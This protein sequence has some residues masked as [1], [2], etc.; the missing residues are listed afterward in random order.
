MVTPAAQA[1]ELNLVAADAQPTEL[2]SGAGGHVLGNELAERLRTLENEEAAFYA[3]K[4]LDRC[5]AVE[6]DA[7]LAIVDSWD[8]VA[9]PTLLE[10]FRSL[11][12]AATRDAASCETS[13]RLVISTSSRETIRLLHEQRHMERSEHEHRQSIAVAATAALAA[14]HIGCPWRYVVASGNPRLSLTRA[15][16][17][18]TV[19]KEGTWPIVSPVDPL[20]ATSLMTSEMRELLPHDAVVQRSQEAHDA[21]RDSLHA[22]IHSENIRTRIIQTHYSRERAALPY[23][24]EAPSA[25]IHDHS[26]SIPNC[27]PGVLP[28]AFVEDERNQRLDTDHEWERA[29]ML[30]DSLVQTFQKVVHVE[31]AAFVRLKALHF[32]ANDKSIRA[33]LT[34]QRSWRHYKLQSASSRRREWIRNALPHALTQRLGQESALVLRDQMEAIEDATLRDV[35]AEDYATGELGLYFPYRMQVL[36]VNA[37]RHHRKLYRLFVE[38]LARAVHQFVQTSHSHTASSMRTM[39]FKD[40]VEG[41]EAVLWEQ[42]RH[43]KAILVLR[44]NTERILH[45]VPDYVPNFLPSVT[46]RLETPPSGWDIIYDEDRRG[47]WRRVALC[48]NGW[49]QFRLEQHKLVFELEENEAYT[50]LVSMRGG[51]ASRSARPPSSERIPSAGYRR[52]PQGRVVSSGGPDRIGSAAYRRL[53]SAS[54]AGPRRGSSADAGRGRPSQSAAPRGVPKFWEGHQRVIDAK[55]RIAEAE[56]VHRSHIEQQYTLHEDHAATVCRLLKLPA[57]WCADVA[58]TYAASSLAL[59]FAEASERSLVAEDEAMAA[60]QLLES[61]SALAMSAQLSAVVPPREAA[62]EEAAM[63]HI[64]EAVEDHERRVVQ[65]RIRALEGSLATATEHLRRIGVVARPASSKSRARVPSALQRDSLAHHRSN[66]TTAARVAS[67]IQRWWRRVLGKKLHV[68]EAA[69]AVIHQTALL[70]QQDAAEVR[71]AEVLQSQ[72]AALSDEQTIQRRTSSAT[73]ARQSRPPSSARTSSAARRS[74]TDAPPP[75]RPHSA[76]SNLQGATQESMR[77]VLSR[78]SLQP[79]LFVHWAVVEQEEAASRAE[80]VLMELIH[81]RRIASDFAS[82]FMAAAIAPKLQRVEERQ[83]PANRVRIEREA[84]HAFVAL[85]FCGP[86]EAIRAQAVLDK[87]QRNRERVLREEHAAWHAIATRTLAASETIRMCQAATAMPAALPPPPEW[88]TAAALVSVAA[89]LLKTSATRREQLRAPVVRS[90]PMNRLIVREDVQRTAILHEHV[91]DSRLAFARYFMQQREC[92]E[93]ELFQSWETSMET[94]CTV[95]DDARTHCSDYRVGDAFRIGLRQRE[96]RASVELECVNHYGQVL[97]DAHKDFVDRLWVDDQRRW[98][99]YYASMALS[100]LRSVTDAL[101][102]RLSHSASKIGELIA[103]EEHSRQLLSSLEEMRRESDRLV[104][105][106][107]V[108]VRQSLRDTYYR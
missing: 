99:H 34:L 44:E 42:H 100:M 72:L 29:T 92:L 41:R 36:E 66:F 49:R 5:V 54:T 102:V 3:K 88:N 83:E 8:A 71:S 101:E 64:L 18:D 4:M 46:E 21:A 38:S 96:A 84:L 97:H 81:W 16:P 17:L 53:G 35:W 68:D 9:L 78:R 103:I 93:R 15:A 45:A 11:C 39:F 40:E 32:W 56:K 28:W 51:S 26:C 70:V 105:A 75:S 12:V 63:R 73:A 82:V 85:F 47:E 107:H 27:L 22:M 90:E 57:A 89:R 106:S 95:F 52:A 48:A 69:L 58:G 86:A 20:L 60:R 2:L 31:A 55:L 80:W 25:T 79:Q 23:D 62:V 74:P 30:L 10:A 65:H 33:T 37:E 50:A 59:S 77:T 14:A 19:D 87:E 98:R 76:V 24:E 61:A 91:A 7:R 13:S 6:L 43:Y 1:D 108:V 67:V 94:A 104:G